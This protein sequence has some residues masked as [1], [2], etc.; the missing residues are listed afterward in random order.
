MLIGRLHGFEIKRTV[1][2]RATASMHQAKE[3]L[4]LASLSIVHS[5]KATFNLGSGIRAIAAIDILNEL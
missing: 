1:A 4:G 5:G 2:P 3:L